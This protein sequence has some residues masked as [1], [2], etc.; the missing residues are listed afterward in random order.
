MA[1]KRKTISLAVGSTN[2]SPANN[3]LAGNASFTRYIR[4]VH[5]VN[6]TAGALTL[7]AGAGV[8]AVLAVT[9]SDICSGLS[10]P[11][12]SM[13]PVAFYG[14]SGKRCEGTGTAN[15]FMAIAQSGTNSLFITIVYDESDTLDA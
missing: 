3:I 8:A 2:T 1:L 6:N 5:C 15:A 4:S 14:G 9:N 7:T 12:N 11:A 10:I 13:T